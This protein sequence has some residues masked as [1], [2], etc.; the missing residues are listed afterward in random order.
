MVFIF[1]V[2][3]EDCWCGFGISVDGM[4]VNKLVEIFQKDCRLC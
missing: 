3:D 2:M 4:V 1:G